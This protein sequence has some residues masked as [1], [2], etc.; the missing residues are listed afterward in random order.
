MQ[1]TLEEAEDWNNQFY[2]DGMHV[3][4]KGL[5]AM[6]CMVAR[7]ADRHEA[8]SFDPSTDM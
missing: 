7:F 4:E 6:A 3:N 2:L 1:R 8:T 5:E